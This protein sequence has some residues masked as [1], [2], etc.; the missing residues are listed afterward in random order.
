MRKTL[1]AVANFEVLITRTPPVARYPVC[2]GADG[3][4]VWAVFVRFTNAPPVF[5]IPRTICAFAQS[6]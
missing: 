1:V 5:H 4:T 6:G 3:I 2:N